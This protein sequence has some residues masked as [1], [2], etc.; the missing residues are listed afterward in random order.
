M[1]KEGKVEMFSLE[2]YSSS[3]PSHLGSLHPEDLLQ[4]PPGETPLIPGYSKCPHSQAQSPL[5][6]L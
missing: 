2:P 1:D 5:H 3:L 6:P 4:P